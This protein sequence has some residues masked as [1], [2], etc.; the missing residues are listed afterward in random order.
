LI[1]VNC[2]AGSLVE[3]NFA[4]IY[5]REPISKWGTEIRWWLTLWKVQ[6]STFCALPLLRRRIRRHFGELRKH[7][8]VVPPFRI[9][10][11]PP[12]PPSKAKLPIGY[13][14]S[15][16]D[17]PFHWPLSHGYAQSPPPPLFP[18]L[19]R[20]GLQVSSVKLKTLNAFY[21]YSRSFAHPKPYIKNDRHEKINNPVSIVFW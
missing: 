20:L 2:T 6:Q 5:N 8:L 16:S 15:G 4:K 17:V 19:A 21:G 9:W 11:I 1:V 3:G 12:I 14:L 13:N 18:P 10:T 7:F